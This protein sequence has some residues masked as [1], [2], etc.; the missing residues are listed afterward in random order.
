MRSKI[1]GIRYLTV[2]KSCGMLCKIR[3]FL[4]CHGK[5]IIYK[6][7][8]FPTALEAKMLEQGKGSRLRENRQRDHV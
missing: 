8:S 2:D 6:F 3:K 7:I 5:R 4:P 1:D